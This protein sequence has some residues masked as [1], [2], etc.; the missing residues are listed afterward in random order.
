M[1]STYE[2]TENDAEEEHFASLY[3]PVT[4]VK[5]LKTFQKISKNQA[6]PNKLFRFTQMIS[7]HG[8]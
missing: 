1:I 7:E 5:R 4:S 3:G 2:K 6:F 8:N